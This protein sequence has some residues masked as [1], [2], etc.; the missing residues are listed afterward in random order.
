MDWIEYFN[1]IADNHEYIINS[2]KTCAIIIIVFIFAP[3]GICGIPAYNFTNFTKEHIT[4]RR[5][6]LKMLLTLPCSL[7]NN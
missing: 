2:D 3:A 7:K 4:N 6:M 1:H 5:H